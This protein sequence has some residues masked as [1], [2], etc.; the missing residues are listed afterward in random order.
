MHK[1]LTLTQREKKKIVIASRETSANYA[2][3]IHGEG[4]GGG[5]GRKQLLEVRIPAVWA[6]LFSGKVGGCR[7]VSIDCK[8]NFVEF[9]PKLSFFFRSM[10]VRDIFRRL[11]QKLVD[12]SSDIFTWRD[13]RWMDLPSLHPFSPLQRKDA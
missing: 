12:I 7:R 10:N 8:S 13:E 11:I 5:I 2:L 9:F 1:P 4:G 6:D 3:K